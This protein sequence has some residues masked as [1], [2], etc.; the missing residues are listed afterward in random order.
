MRTDTTWKSCLAIMCLLA[1]TEA[2]AQTEATR[3][4]MTISDCRFSRP[5]AIIASLKDAPEIAAEFE[6]QGLVVADVGEPFVP[7]DVIDSSKNLPRRQFLR[8]YAFADRT[9]GW[10]YH[11]G[12]GTH[13]HVFE[14]RKQV[15]SD[16]GSPKEPVLRLTGATLSGPPCQAT[17][18]LLDG[19]RSLNDW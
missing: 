4:D 2:V 8:A 19:V 14:L 18:A 12:L 1:G 3:P 5:A 13:I 10:Y 17:Q 9:I 16:S 7:Y 6:R 15:A 11:G